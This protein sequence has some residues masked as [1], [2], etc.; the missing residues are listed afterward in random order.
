MKAYFLKIH[1]KVILQADILHVHPLSPSHTWRKKK[2]K[3]SKSPVLF[4]AIFNRAQTEV[5]WKVTRFF[6]SLTPEV[7][8]IV[9]QPFTE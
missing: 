2:K 8:S 7:E 1:P 5:N 3:N 6:D 4:S 9:I